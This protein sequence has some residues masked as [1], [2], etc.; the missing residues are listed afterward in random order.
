MPET[1][2]IDSGSQDILYDVWYG[3][4]PEYKWLPKTRAAAKR[5]L[6]KQYKNADE[7]AKQY[8]FNVDNYGC[9]T[10][11]DWSCSHWGSKWNF[12]DVEIIDEP[13]ALTYLHQSAW[14]PLTP[15]VQKMGEMFPLLR[16]ELKYEEPGC[17][18]R[19]TFIMLNG[20]V[21]L[22]Q[23]REYMEEISKEDQEEFYGGGPLPR[24]VV[25]VKERAELD[26]RYAKLKGYTR[27][28][29]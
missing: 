12:R 27:L 21:F 26:P 29:E 16:F 10:W 7:L 11:Y 22:D 4:M 15:V 2:R 23:C 28:K 20:H 6:R 18:F 19:G 13:D 24:G 17:G 25:V 8:K 14:S 5:H 1:L 9:K 3:E